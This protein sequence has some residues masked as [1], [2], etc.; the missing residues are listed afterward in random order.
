MNKENILDFIG[1]AS[2]MILTVG[3]MYIVAIIAR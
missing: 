3:L 1:V 2:A